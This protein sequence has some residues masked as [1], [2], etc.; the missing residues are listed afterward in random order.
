MRLGKQ[1]FHYY[2]CVGYVRE[3]EKVP[4]VLIVEDDFM[5]ADWLEEVLVAAGYEVCGIAGTVAAAIALGKQHRP[6]LGVIDVRLAQGGR[7][8]E[9][10][11]ALRR[12]GG[13]GVLYATGN[14]VYP[15]LSSA[16]GEGCIVKPYSGETLIAALH[17]VAEVAAGHPVSGALPRDFR[18]LGAAA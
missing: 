1:V 6:D 2:L 7:G 8:T 11:A 5:I 17:I 16:Q 18:L 12:H 13:F 10:A 3:A 9:V 4:K 14:T 15:V